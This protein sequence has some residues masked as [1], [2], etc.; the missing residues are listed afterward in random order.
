MSRN[1]PAIKSS[2]ASSPLISNRGGAVEEC[3]Y[4]CL[5]SQYSIIFRS[6]ALEMS[7]SLTTLVRCS[8]KSRERL[9]ENSRFR[10]LLAHSNSYT[11][12]NSSPSLDMSVIGVRGSSASDDMRGRV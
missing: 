6:A 11:T 5:Y 4:V 9:H 8:S 2:N 1:S 12:T 7:R 10:T 3:S